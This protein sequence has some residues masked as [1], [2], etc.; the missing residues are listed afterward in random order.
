MQCEIR[1]ED[2]N[3]KTK[4]EKSERSSLHVVSAVSFVLSVVDQH[5]LP[6]AV[7]STIAEILGRLDFSFWL[8]SAV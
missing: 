1:L 4:E 7:V 8:M 6:Y 2:R 5:L 3:R